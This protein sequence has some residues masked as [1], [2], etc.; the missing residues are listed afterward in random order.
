MYQAF[1]AIISLLGAIYAFGTKQPK[2]GLGYL[3]YT[4]AFILLIPNLA[5]GIK[6]DILGAAALVLFVA[7]S[8]LIAWKKKKQDEKKNEEE[9]NQ[10]SKSN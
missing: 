10:E 5:E 1:L 6:A 2:I 8:F 9:Q 3:V 4:G 7:G